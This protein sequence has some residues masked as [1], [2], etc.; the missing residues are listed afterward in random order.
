M[1]ASATK[2]RMTMARNGPRVRSG[3]DI[4]AGSEPAPNASLATI[5]HPTTTG[6]VRPAAA[7]CVKMGV[8]STAR[9]RSA[10]RSALRHRP[11]GPMQYDDALAYCLGKPGAVQ[12]EPWEGDVVVKVGGKIFAFFG[13]PEG[14][15]IGLKCGADADEAEGWRLELPEHVTVM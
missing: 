6:C 15:T 10:P 5:A 2:I 4:R 1:Q 13:M 7:S 14:G 11:G 3:S 12:D 9:D 8:A